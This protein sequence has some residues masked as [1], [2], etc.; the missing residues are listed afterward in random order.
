MSIFG[1]CDKVTTAVRA[2]RPNALNASSGHPS[3]KVSS[4]NR[5]AL[6]KQMNDILM[7]NYIKVP[8][9]KVAIVSGGFSQ[10]VD[11]L[12]AELGIDHAVANEL[13][14][15]DGVLTG[16]TVGPVVDRER[17]GEVLRELAAAEGLELAQ[18]VAVGDGANDLGM[19]SAAGLGIAFN[20]KPVVREAADTSVTVPYLD[21][22]L[23]LLG[24]RRDEVER[25]DAAAGGTRD[26]IEVPGL[27]PV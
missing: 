25:A 27:P 17:K 9:N 11:H 15:V 16:R 22:I 23:F 24:I 12:A 19:L 13:E 6:A 8:P 7:Q 21:A 10:V 1:S 20:A 26:E 14:V 18:C 2:S 4:G 3:R 5:A